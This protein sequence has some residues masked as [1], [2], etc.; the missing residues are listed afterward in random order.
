MT[1]MLS[2]INLDD[3]LCDDKIL[4]KIIWEIFYVTFFETKCNKFVA[5]NLQKSPLVKL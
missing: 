1:K 2:K 5:K 4:R 3:F